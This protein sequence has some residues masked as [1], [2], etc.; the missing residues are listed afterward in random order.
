MSRY[1]EHG[2][3]FVE[4]ADAVEIGP[5]IVPDEPSDAPDRTLARAVV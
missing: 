5:S 3:L 1:E 2:A 4:Y